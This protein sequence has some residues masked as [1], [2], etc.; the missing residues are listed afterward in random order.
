MDYGCGTLGDMGVH[1]FDTPYNALTLDV[2]RTIKN[3]CRKPTGFGFPENNVVTYEFPGTKYTG[4]SLKWVWHDGP[5]APKDHKELELP[6]AKK[7]AKSKKG[8]ASVEEKMSLE[9]KATGEGVLPD[10]GAMF[11]GE[12]GRLLLPHFMEL[13]KKIVD[14][15]Y[16]DIT[17]EIAEVGKT[18]NMGE[19][20]RDY[21]SEGVKHYHQFVEACLGR[22][23]CSAPF[24]YASKLT[25][26]IL[27]G[28]IAG[29]FPNKTLHW[30]NTTAKFAEE[31]A[32]QYLESPYRDF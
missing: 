30:D 23:E 13:P 25:E 32:N 2:P 27:L 1:I 21:A 14:G 31:E 3:E 22:G 24:S 7:K 10:Q 16:V 4:D 17:K 11:I 29:R 26:T 20:I 6:N 8:E 28:V 18:H 5:G 9:T 19:P 15:E 12:K